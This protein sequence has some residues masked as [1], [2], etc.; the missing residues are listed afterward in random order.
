MN[1]GDTLV[2]KW[3]YDQTNVD[4]YIVLKRTPKMVT[5]TKVKVD[6]R[7]TGDMT[8]TATPSIPLVPVGP[9][10]SF[11]IKE[12]RGDPYVKIAHGS[13]YVWDGTPQKG[14]SYA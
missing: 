4:F 10:K 8:Y 7:A 2:S 1:N 12:Y 6:Q 9:T 13:A 11:R 3:G 5:V 14:T